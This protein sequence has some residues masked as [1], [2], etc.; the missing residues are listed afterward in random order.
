MGHLTISHPQPLEI[1]RWRPFFK[2]ATTLVEQ[3]GLRNH[4]PW[5]GGGGV[6]GCGCGYVGMYGDVFHLMDEHNLGPRLCSS[7]D[8]RVTHSF[9]MA[10]IFDREHHRCYK[11]D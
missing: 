11:V 6:G 1:S 4:E 2:M 8:S 5:G 3:L 9:S 10:V 7:L